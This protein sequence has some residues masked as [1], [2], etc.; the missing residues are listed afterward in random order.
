MTAKHTSGS[1]AGVVGAQLRGSA[2]LA[3]THVDA[4]DRAGAAALTFIRSSAF[5]GAWAASGASAALVTRGIEVP[6][7][8]GATRALLI[9]DDA[10]FALVKVLELFAPAPEAAR[11]GVHPSAVV[12]PS[13]KIAGSASIGPCCVVGAGTTI[14]EGVVLVG[15]VNVGRGAVIGEGTVLYPG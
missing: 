4:L 13:A 12:D 7:H 8:D 6:G 2:D 10:D 3:I 14:G 15:S 1:I 9:V 11:P 5:A